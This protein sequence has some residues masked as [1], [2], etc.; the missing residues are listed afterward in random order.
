MEF[1]V[2]VGEL[3]G[4][5]ELEWEDGIFTIPFSNSNSELELITSFLEL[6]LGTRAFQTFLRL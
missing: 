5:L 3:S 2:G 4:R 1:R 6:G